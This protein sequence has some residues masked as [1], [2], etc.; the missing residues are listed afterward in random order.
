[1]P[2]WALLPLSIK[3]FDLF[4]SECREA[5]S[6]NTSPM[7]Y[8]QQKECHCLLHLGIA[9]DYIPPW[10]GAMPVE[11]VKALKIPKVGKIQ[12]IYYFTFWFVIKNYF[13]AITV[14]FLQV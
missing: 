4:T 11:A 13:K 6:L 8:S 10:K 1:M 5:F 7:G 2:L 14:T 9:A 3:R 12:L